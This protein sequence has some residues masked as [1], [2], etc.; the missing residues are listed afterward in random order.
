MITPS[1]TILEMSRK[2]AETYSLNEA[3]RSSLIADYLAF[4]EKSAIAPGQDT[5]L[6]PTPLVDALWH[7]HILHTRSYAEDCH[8]WFGFIVHHVPDDTPTATL[9]DCSASGKIKPL[10]HVDDCNSSAL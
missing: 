5:L 9:G 7:E 10:A 1:Q 2:V 8:A 3:V 6:R 4:L